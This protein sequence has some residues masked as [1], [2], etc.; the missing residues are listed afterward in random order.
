MVDAHIKLAHG[1][2]RYIGIDDR[3]GLEKYQLHGIADLV[4]LISKVRKLTGFSTE[5]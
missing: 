1:L 5:L 3:K 4:D 2:V